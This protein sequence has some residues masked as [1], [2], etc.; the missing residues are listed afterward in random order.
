MRET[1]D[2]SNADIVV[3]LVLQMNEWCGKVV[4]KILTEYEFSSSSEEPVA[5][6]LGE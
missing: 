6:M 1:V 5:S 2:H 3:I 4:E